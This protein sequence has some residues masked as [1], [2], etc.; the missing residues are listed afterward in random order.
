MTD[1]LDA[2]GLS[3]DD[4]ET[5]QARVIGEQRTLISPTLSSDTSE[6]EGQ[7]TKITVEHIQQGFEF[8]QEIY[9]SMDPDQATG[10]SLDA[11]GSIRGVP[12]RE[13]SE[14]TVSLDCTFTG[15]VVLGTGTLTAVSGDPTNLWE[16]ITPYT[17]PGAGTFSVNFQS[18]Q[19]GPI[20]APLG[21][22]TVI[23]TPVAGWT[24]V[25]NP[26]AAVPGS[27]IESDA[28]Y[29]NRQE[30]EL[31]GPGSATVIGVRAAVSAVTGVLE[32]YVYENTSWRAVAPLPPHSIEAVYWDGG[33]GAADTDEIAEAIFE[34]AGG[35]KAYGSTTVVTYTDSQGIDHLIG[36]TLAAEQV[37]DVE[38][39]LL[40]GDNYVGDA[41]V[42]AAIAAWD[43]T[44]LGIG[45]DVYRSKISGIVTALEG[46]ENVSL[47]RLSTT[48]PGGLANV[49]IVISLRQIATIAP[50]DIT[51]IS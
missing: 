18:T 19:T 45:D 30:V 28:D 51:V 43:D 14:G 20:E 23:V 22:I 11:I 26:A 50:G 49:D 13:A 29:R 4:N 33:A 35:I 21:T 15:V 9:N 3:I 2:T 42:I 24:A 10:H 46:V 48:G 31:A 38:V 41:A 17:S 25:N 5:R 7:F 34:K 44:T 40:Q 39:T 1:E 32:V 47:V 6:P 12:R 37:I 36:M 16:I 27:A 8:L